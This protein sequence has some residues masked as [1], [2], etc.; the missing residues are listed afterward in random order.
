LSAW[1]ALKAGNPV[2]FIWF[3]PYYPPLTY[4]VSAPF[5][6][7]FSRDLT[8]LILSQSPFWLLLS[9]SLY[10]IGKKLFSPLTGFLGTFYFLTLPVTLCWAQYYMLDIPC[11]AMTCLCFYLMLKTDDFKNPGYSWGFGLALGLGLLQKWWIVLMLGGALLLYLISVYFGSFRDWR[12]RIA[13]LLIPGAVIW[14]HI[15]I[16]WRL[17]VFIYWENTLD[18]WKYFLISLGLAALLWILLRLLSRAVSKNAP[19]TKALDNFI[20]ALCLAYL[21]A[22][23]LYLNPH[24]GLLN[25]SL[26]NIGAV[27]EAAYPGLDIY[28]RLT[29]DRVT[30]TEFPPLN[31]CDYLVYSHYT[32]AGNFNFG[33]QFKRERP[34]LLKGEKLE[35]KEVSSY[36]IPEFGT[37]F[38]LFKIIEKR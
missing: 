26:F 16:A 29:G 28:P 12:C 2:N 37:R 5:Y 6:A 34:D 13:G 19:Q 27:G 4:W 31:E 7:L 32:G 17:R 33:E 23:W 38:H 25:G 8:V 36:N 18:F 1:Q 14:L 20:N 9:F 15:L 21:L 10:G 11:A 3:H 24:F 35:F 22:G 30:V